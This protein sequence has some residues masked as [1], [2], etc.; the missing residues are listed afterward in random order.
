MYVFYRWLPYD[1]ERDE[2]SL[3]DVLLMQ[4]DMMY[5][6]DVAVLEYWLN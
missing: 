3:F 4:E 5:D 2:G 1:Q 6:Y